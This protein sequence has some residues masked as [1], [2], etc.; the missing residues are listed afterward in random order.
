[1]RFDTY[2][3]VTILPDPDI[4]AWDCT[5]KVWRMLH[6]A[7][8]K[9]QV[10]FAVS[11][12][13][14]MSDGFTLGKDIRFFAQGTPAI[15]RF[16]D[17]LE[18]VPR[19]DEFA[20]ASRVRQVKRIESFEAYMMCRLPGGISRARKTIPLDTQQQ[21]REQAK[22]RRMAEQQH[23]PFVRMRSSSGTQFRLTIERVAAL[24]THQGKPSS[25][26]LSRAT[27]IVAVPVL[28]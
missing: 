27:Q 26:G 4:P 23:L 20:A 2:F 14:W 16:Y 25:Y 7:G 9:S 22:L 8:V 6:S 11:F 28:A 19:F 18:E 17:R 24:E 15:E 12:P 13:G 1:M 10:E 5:G 3:D 21:L